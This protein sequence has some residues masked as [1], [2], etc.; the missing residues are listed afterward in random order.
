M[1]TSATQSAR[2]VDIITPSDTQNLPREARGVY[3]G[4]GGHMKITTQ[5]GKTVIF[6]NLVRGQILPVQVW[7]V[8]QTD[9]TASDLI[10]L[11]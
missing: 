10:A 2:D 1:A 5:Y 11:Y 7:K 9:T 4:T 3:I 6:K 8:W